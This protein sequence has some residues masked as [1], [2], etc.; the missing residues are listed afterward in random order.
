ML[1]REP[2]R[3]VHFLFATLAFN[4]AAYQLFR[5]FTVTWDFAVFRWLSML[6]SVSL[7]ATAQRFFRS[8]LRDELPPPLSWSTV[9]GAILAYIALT[10]S[11]FISPFHDTQWFRVSLGAYVF[12]GLY[13][14][15]Y[16]LYRRYRATESRVDKIRL[17]YL[18]VG[19]LTAITTGL[20]ERTAVGFTFSGIITVIYL[21]FLSQ[22]LVRFRLMDLNELL[23]RMMVLAILVLMLTSVFAVLVAWVDTRENRGVFF[24]NA[25]IA[26]TAILILLDPLRNRIEGEVNR[27]LF[28]EKYEL[29]RR[30]EGLRA[31][32]ANI[33][34]VQRLAPQ[35]VRA[36]EN[37][38]RVT[39]ASIYYS[40]PDGTGFDLAGHIGPKPINRFDAVAN[41][42][43][44]DRLRRGGILTQDGVDR[45]LASLPDNMTEE[46]ENAHQFLRAFENLQGSVIAAIVNEDQLLGLFVLKDDR[47]RE[48][49]GSDELEI[50]RSVASSIG[51]TLRNSQ[52]YEKMQERDRLAALGQM[53]AGLAH[54]IRNPLGS[55]KGA[56]QFLRPK[57]SPAGV[58]QTSQGQGQGPGPRP[59][60]RCHHNRILG[61][62]HRG[63]QP[64]EP[65]GLSVFGLC[66]PLSRRPQSSGLK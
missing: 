61:H 50:F 53:A 19:G 17:V 36:L 34:D 49:F 41:H 57:S 23:G 14:S 22:S 62:H 10:L 26:S 40:D 11:L 30:V 31:E 20:L 5:F 25:I 39:H 4:I 52:L 37:T 60:D 56:A 35:V 28:K 46:R 18:L 38:R 27:W 32:I 48:A 58:D 9:G 16:H 66:T 43:L 45:E 44:L 65:D 55:I 3:G 21:F 47:T 24:F 7:P 59:R 29:F 15:V 12:I 1:L 33:V 13:L 6:A 42:N 51:I 63:D 2:R 8:F 54:E 64:A